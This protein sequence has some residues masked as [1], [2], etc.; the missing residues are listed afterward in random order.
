MP[1]PCASLHTSA[2]HNGAT[3]LVPPMEQS[4]SMLFFAAVTVSAWHGGLGPGLLATG[5]AWGG[6]AGYRDYTTGR[7]NLAVAPAVLDQP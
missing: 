2:A 5:Y 7:D 3:A 4:P 6:P 1:A